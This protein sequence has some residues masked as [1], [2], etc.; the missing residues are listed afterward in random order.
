MLAWL[1]R[2]SPRRP[3]RPGHHGVDRGRASPYG[4]AS[5]SLHRLSHGVLIRRLGHSWGTSQGTARDNPGH[6]QA[7]R[8]GRSPARTPSPWTRPGAMPSM[9]CK[10][11]GVQ[12]P[13]APPG[14]THLPAPLERRLLE[15]CQTAA[16]SS[17]PTRICATPASTERP[18]SI[19]A[20]A[21]GQDQRAVRS[22]PP[23]AVS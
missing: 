20:S 7:Y 13:S 8:H 9:A 14:T 23:P 3:R 4:R 5:P 11:S 12:I 15:T 10:G 22:V 18:A 21:G 16:S 1:S 17:I 19:A 6:P 2:V